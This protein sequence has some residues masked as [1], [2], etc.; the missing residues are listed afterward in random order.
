MAGLDLCV[1]DGAIG[2]NLDKQHNFAAY[3]HA[4]GEFGIDGWDAADDSAMDVAGKGYARSESETADANERTSSTKRISQL[5][6]PQGTEAVS[7]GA[8]EALTG[9][10]GGREDFREGEVLGGAAGALL[11]VEEEL[12]VAVGETGG[13]ID[14]EVGQ[15]PIDP[16]RRAL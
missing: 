5:K 14:V 12:A 3:V 8:A 6:P 4:V 16:V 1:G 15:R 9:G 2:L 13:V 7:A 11:P 10:E